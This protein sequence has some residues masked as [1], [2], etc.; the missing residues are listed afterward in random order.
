MF[1]DRTFKAGSLNTRAVYQNIQTFYNNYELIVYNRFDFTNL[2]RY[3]LNWR[4]TVD[5]G[6]KEEGKI[7]CNIKPKEKEKYRLDFSLPAKC[8]MGCYLDIFLMDGEQEIAMEQHT[9]PVQI[10]PVVMPLY[11]P[12]R[13]AFRETEEKIRISGKDFEYI[14][15]KHYG[16]F[17]FMERE[18]RVIFD[19]LIKLTVWRCLLYTSK[20][21][22]L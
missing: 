9:I 13:L 18:G 10:E 3:T 2:S 17:E 1:A 11:E 7:I 22:L 21:G 5:G 4:L 6:V 14:F 20:S 16:N 19:Q 12:D 8:K 15:N